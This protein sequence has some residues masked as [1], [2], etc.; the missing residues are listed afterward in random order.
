MRSFPCTLYALIIDITFVVMEDLSNFFKAVSEV[1][2]G[3]VLGPS[4]FILYTLELFSIVENKL[5]R[6]ADDFILVSVVP[7]PLD[8]VAVAESPNRDLNRVSK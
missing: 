1:P 5:Y 4:F 8:I 2:Q 3:G 7:T 6:Y